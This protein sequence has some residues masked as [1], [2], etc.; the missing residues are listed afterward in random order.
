MNDRT[1][2]SAILDQVKVAMADAVGKELVGYNKPLSTLCQKVISA[3]ESELYALI[4]SEV[5]ALIGGD[6]FKSA[7]KDALND[8]LARVMVSRLG[9]ELEKRVNDLKADATT[10][11]KMTLAINNAI[12]ECLRG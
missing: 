3:H 12:D 9:G 11:A 1:L 5:S 4:N 8:K 7:L 6:G 2:E 10:R